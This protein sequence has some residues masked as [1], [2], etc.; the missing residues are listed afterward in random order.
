MAYEEK[1]DNQLDRLGCPIE[2]ENLSESLWNDKCD[3]L[4]I[5]E[6]TNL[7]PSNY[8]MNILQL[9]NRSLLSHQHEL[10]VLLQHLCNKNSTIDVVVLK[11][12]RETCQYLRIYITLKLSQ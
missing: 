7:N 5:K 9:N 8:N 4:N 3:Y 12:G 11:K 6:C 10:K 2:I 1:T